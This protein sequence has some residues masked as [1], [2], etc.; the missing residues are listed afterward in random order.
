MRFSIIVLAIMTMVA[1]QNQSTVQ[2]QENPSIVLSPTPVSSSKRISG[3]ISEFHNMSN[4]SLWHYLTGRRGG[5]LTGGQYIRGGA[6][7]SP[8]CIMTHSEGWD[9]FFTR[10]T[11]TLTAYLLARLADTTTTKIH[12]C[13]FFE[14][15]AGE[16]A[17]YSLQ[18]LYK[19]NWFDFEEFASYKSREAVSA[20]ENHQAWLQQVLQDEKERTKMINCWKQKAGSQIR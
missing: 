3:K 17:V 6:F 10:D 11:G 20:T 8:A 19:T 9:N 1:C 16:V 5:C 4:D 14:A 18:K 13:P 7:G 12:T 2:H 15:M